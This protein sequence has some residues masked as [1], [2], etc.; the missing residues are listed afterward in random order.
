MK[1]NSAEIEQTLDQFEAEVD[2]GALFVGS[3]E[4]VAVKIAAVVRGLDLQRFDLKYASGT[5]PH[6]HLMEAIRLY[7]TEVIPRVGELLA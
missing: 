4:T 3:P 7:G 1:L 5:M 6:E 2:G